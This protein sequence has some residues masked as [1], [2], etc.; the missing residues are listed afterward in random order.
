VRREGTSGFYHGPF[1][2][3]SKKLSAR[4]VMCKTLK[5][6]RI[7]FFILWEH[8]VYRG[9]R[10]ISSTQVQLLSR[11]AMQT[12][13]SHGNCF[14][15]WLNSTSFSV[16]FDLRYVSFDLRDVFFDLSDIALDLSLKTH[17]HLQTSIR[18]GV[19]T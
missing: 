8:I 19:V 1:R 7:V 2:K 9:D 10:R 12:F 3:E 14:N 6:G 13:N 5:T 11:D 15:V 18:A 4:K 16:A 17:F